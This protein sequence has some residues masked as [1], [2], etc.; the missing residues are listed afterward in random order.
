MTSILA[1]PARSTQAF[2]RVIF[3]IAG[4]LAWIASGAR[5]ADAAIKAFAIPRGD[6]TVTLKQFTAQAGVQLLYTMNTV[7]GVMS[8]PVAGKITPREAL[9][10]MFAGT[11]LTVM[12]DENNGA[13]SLVKAIPIKRPKE[14]AGHTRRSSQ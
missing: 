10:R 14:A 6:A 1:S 8:H 9:T 13:L 7:R 12:Q 4:M 11:G 2:G 5:A 3:A